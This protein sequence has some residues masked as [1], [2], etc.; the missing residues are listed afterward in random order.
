MT[1]GNHEFDGGEEPLVAFIKN[2]TF[3]VI[4][5]NVNSTNTA[6]QQSLVPYKVFPKHDLAV[7]A[8]T[9]DT[10]PGISN[11]GAGQCSAIRQGFHHN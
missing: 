11:P 3:P 9:T 7:V 5:A 10:I 2:L 1:L 8:V 4:C 6:L